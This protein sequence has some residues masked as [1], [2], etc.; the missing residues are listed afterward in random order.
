MAPSWES[1]NFTKSNENLNGE[2]SSSGFIDLE[3]AWAHRT[4][5]VTECVLYMSASVQRWLSW[6][7][8]SGCMGCTY[9]LWIVLLKKIV[10]HHAML[11][12]LV[13]SRTRKRENHFPWPAFLWPFDHRMCLFKIK[14]H[15]RVSVSSSWH[16]HGDFM[17]DIA[18]TKSSTFSFNSTW[19]RGSLESICPSWSLHSGL[20]I[21]SF[22]VLQFHF[23]V[24]KAD[25]FQVLKILS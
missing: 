16:V 2:F 13:H 17:V 12:C 6:S 18:G 4:T 15:Q 1:V 10:I 24:H 8:F 23:H 9:A 11:N 7:A 14:V 20:K 25:A 3:A 22:C 5:A 19:Q 21:Y